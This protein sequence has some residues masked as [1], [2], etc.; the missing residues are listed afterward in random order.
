M[1]R[2]QKIWI[3]I[4]TLLPFLFYL[5]YFLNFLLFFLNTKWMNKVF[6]STNIFLIFPLIAAIIISAVVML[7]IYAYQI[8]KNKKL[9]ELEKL[10]WIIIVL[11]GLSF[12]Q[13]IYYFIHITNR[14]KIL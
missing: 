4:G 1:S 7:I 5:A 14:K 13:L 8:V 11:V 12:G 3:L 10:L 2:T 6:L 9:S